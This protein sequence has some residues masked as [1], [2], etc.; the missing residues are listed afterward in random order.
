MFQGAEKWDMGAITT[1]I[2]IIAFLILA[3]GLFS[4]V[5]M[6]VVSARKIRLQQ[7]VEDGDEG[8]QAAL[9]L[10]EQPTR[11]LS[12][13]QIGIT[14]IGVLTGAVGGATIAEE[15]AKVFARIDWLTPYSGALGVAIVVLIITYLSLV[16]GELVPKR[17]AL[18]GPE[19]IAARFAAPMGRLSRLATPL[20]SILSWSTETVVRLLGIV[21]KTGPEVTEE[22][23][24][25]MIYEGTQE[26]VFEVA[27][28][29]IMKRVFRLGDRRVSTLMTY[30]ADI[31]W[32]DVD[33]PVSENLEKIQS[34]GHSRYPVCREELDDVLGIISIN[35]LFYRSQRGEPFDL[36]Q[37]LNPPLFLT[38]SMD[39][40]EA[41]DKLKLAREHGA[42]VIDEFGSVAGLVTTTDLLEA[43]VG[44]MPSLQE[45]E[46]PEI[47]RRDDGSWLLDGM[48]PIED[49]KE[50]LEIDRL[51]LEDEGDYETLG[52]MMMT[53]L[54]RIP[55]PS[56][57]FVWEL[58]DF[59]VVDMDG[60]RVDKVLV[61][62]TSKPGKQENA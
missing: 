55:N 16:F 60:Y 3:N 57:H 17:L 44:E 30:R 31:V 51:P 23:V 38:E 2:F 14:L 34:T 52:G 47:V 26:G 21:P 27:E 50:L 61:T 5:E 43:I 8:A 11:F 45:N 49:V 40:L 25:M 37:D 20:V 28:E 56:D 24:R 59:E 19:T 58:F 42:L 46:E 54:G 62:P 15:L 39:G 33:D 53:H 32:L 7:R 9:N 6:A 48:L 35:N 10:T 1:E 18:N 12:T 36:L 29:A 22:D 13:V 4:M 41:L